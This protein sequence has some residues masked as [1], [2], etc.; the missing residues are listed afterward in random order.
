MIFKNLTKYQKNR[1]LAAIV[2]ILFAIIVSIFQA[3]SKNF[4]KTSEIQKAEMISTEDSYISTLQSEIREKVLKILDDAEVQKT[5][6]R[7]KNSDEF[8]N[9]DGA[10]FLNREKR[11]PIKKDREYYAEWTV[12]TP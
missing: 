2:F 12:K 11:L 7:I 10:V 4:E 1:L 6:E 9:K 3:V 5:L 8:Y